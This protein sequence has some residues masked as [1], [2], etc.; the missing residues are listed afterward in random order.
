[1]S[2]GDPS[3]AGA[4]RCRRFV[5]VFKTVLTL[6]MILCGSRATKLAKQSSGDSWVGKRV[7]TQF[8]TLLQVGG[9]VVDDAGRGKQLARGRDNQVFRIYKVEQ[10]NGPWL[11]L[12]AEGSGVK[13]WA[14]AVNVIPFDHAID[15]LTNRI[16]ANPGATANYLWRAHVWRARKEYDIA[17]TDLNEAIR[18]D[19]GF[20][21]AYNNRGNAWRAKKEYDKAIA[22]YNEAIRIDPG[23]AAAYSNRG[24]A[25]SDKKEYDKAIADYNEAI[26]IDPG[27]A[28]AYYNRGV[29]KLITERS[30]AVEDAR[31]TYELSGTKGELAPYAVIVGYL[32]AR[33]QGHDQDAR[34]TLNQGANLDSSA[35]PVP[36]VRFYRGELSRS[37]MMAPATDNDKQTEAHCFLGYERLLAGDRSAARQQFEW[38]RDHG[39]PRFTEYTMSLAELE[40]LSR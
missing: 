18:I 35:W 16:R 40:K 3:V 33:R 11:W 27:F 4:V 34:T 9:Q 38:V 10:L 39:N 13:G 28:I 36:I 22:D 17:I 20:A 37:D 15:Y 26:R 32:G 14:P 21:A 31:R 8:G 29:V 24:L 23:F 12:V 1:M 7:I 2:G 19:P 25:W 30:G 5:R 6:P